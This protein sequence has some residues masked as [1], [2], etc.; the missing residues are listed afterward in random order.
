MYVYMHKGNIL[1]NIPYMKGE[2][3]AYTLGCA[4]RAIFFLV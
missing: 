1:T 3:G 4:L 2:N